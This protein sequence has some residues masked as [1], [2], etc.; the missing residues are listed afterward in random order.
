[1]QSCAF[2]ARAD[3]CLTMQQVEKDAVQGVLQENISKSLPENQEIIEV[4]NVLK[5][6]CI[7]S[8]L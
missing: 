3:F 5:F 8:L 4:M 6:V 1:M 2:Q 7:D